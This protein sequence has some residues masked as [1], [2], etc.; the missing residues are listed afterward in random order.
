ME[1]LI[2]MST[3]SQSPHEPDRVAKLEYSTPVLV[4]YGSIAQITEANKLYRAIDPAPPATPPYNHTSSV[5]W[6]DII[7]DKYADLIVPVSI[8]RTTEKVIICPYALLWSK[9]MERSS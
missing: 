5:A 2:I 7:I 3:N 9:T 1:E 8:L 6:R 4:E